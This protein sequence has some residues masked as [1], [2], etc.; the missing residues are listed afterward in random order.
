VLLDL[1]EECDKYGVV[2][3]VVVPRPDD[4]K[5]AAA[6][7]GTANYGKVRVME[8]FLFC[9]VREQYVSTFVLI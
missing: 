3:D 1:R 4:P 8:V 6:L 5:Q 2:T 7:L 9:G